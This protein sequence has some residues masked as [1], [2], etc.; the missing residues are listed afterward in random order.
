MPP[1]IWFLRH[2]QAEPV[3][4]KPDPERELTEQGERQALAAGRALARLGVQLAACY[5]SPRVRARRTAL[6]ACGPLGLTPQEVPRLAGGFDHHDALDLLY[7]HEADERVL[8]V[9]HEPDL[10]QTIRDLGGGAVELPAGALAAVRVER[11]SGTLLCLL[12]P[13]DLALLATPAGP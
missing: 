9:G 8:L 4:S 11:G 7:A 12:R 13:A 2:G 3:G 5:T 10:S 6:L 1:E